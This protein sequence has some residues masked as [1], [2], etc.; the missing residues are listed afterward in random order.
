V[1]DDGNGK[2]PVEVWLAA[3]MSLMQEDEVTVMKKWSVIVSS[4]L[5][6]IKLM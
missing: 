1:S 5:P 6:E 4:L 3:V 2:S